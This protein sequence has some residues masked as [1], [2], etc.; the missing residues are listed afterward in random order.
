[1]MVKL[2]KALLRLPKHDNE[3]AENGYFSMHQ[4]SFICRLYVATL[5]C[6]QLKTSLRKYSSTSSSGVLVI[7]L[8]MELSIDDKTFLP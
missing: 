6:W 5:M 8:L 1:M 2:K 7:N 4:I 3:K